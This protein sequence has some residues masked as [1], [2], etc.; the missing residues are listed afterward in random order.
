[1]GKKISVHFGINEFD[2]KY[3]GS[4][5]ELGGCI[6]DSKYMKQEAIKQGFTATLYTN[7]ACTKAKYIQRLTE[8]A[9]ELVEGDIFLYSQSSHG[10][11]KVI[12][13]ERHT[14]LCMYDSI[15]WDQET[16]QLLSKFKKGVLIIFISDSCFAQGNYRSISIQGENK[17][18]TKVRYIDSKNIPMDVIYNKKNI[19][20]KANII[21]YGSSNQF[22]SSLDLGDM[23]LFTAKLKEVTGKG[24]LLN[25]FQ[26]FR[27]VEKAIADA[28]Y[29]Q[30]PVFQVENGADTATTYKQ[31]LH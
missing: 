20:F 31:F 28:G 11:F 2:P 18:G 30:S 19:D 5:C 17:E 4:K 3:Y 23:G 24:E 21:A 29:Q 13:G 12:G 26:V 10:T 22:Q 16:K 27:R 25:Y 15:T 7:E 1:M 8:A 14:G 6:N 9:N